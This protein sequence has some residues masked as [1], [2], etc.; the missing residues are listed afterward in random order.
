[1]FEQLSA[2]EVSLEVAA[3]FPAEKISADNVYKIAQRF[4]DSL[5]LRLE[6]DDDRGR[7]RTPRIASSLSMCPNAAVASGGPTRYLAQLHGAERAE[8]ELLIDHFL[9]R[10]PRRSFDAAAFRGSPAESLVE[11]LDASLRGQAGLWPALLPRLRHDAQL[12]RSDVVE[13]LPRPSALPS[14]RRRS[15]A[16]TTRWSRATAAGGRQ[17]QGPRRARKDRQR[18]RRRLRRAGA[19]ITPAGASSPEHAVFARAVPAP[20]QDR[21]AEPTSPGTEPARDDV[22]RLFL[23][24]G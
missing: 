13:Q 16:T 12:K 6:S 3:K 1:V 8:L 18:Q 14:S 10:Q 23:G 20:E 9:M 11:S 5:R 21:A 17:R 7:R 15:P 4:R 19:A 22:D 24:E 2:A